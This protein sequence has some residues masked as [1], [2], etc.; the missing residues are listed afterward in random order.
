MQASLRG[1]LEWHE[2]LQQ[3]PGE[4]AHEFRKNYGYS[5]FDVGNT[6]TWNEAL[7]HL[8]FLKHLPES[9]LHVAMSEG[10]IR[11]PYSVIE[12]ALANQLDV[13]IATAVGKKF[14]PTDR[15]WLSGK[16]GL[17]KVGTKGTIPSNVAIKFFAQLGHK[18]STD[19]KK[20][21]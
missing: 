16:S 9:W 12:E 21:E 18:P 2:L 4:M 17:K 6:V 10:K 14:K 5:I 13:S 15:P 3:Y 1:V 7:I 8:Q 11:R 20:K 19:T